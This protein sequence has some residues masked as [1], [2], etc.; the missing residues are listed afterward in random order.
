[1]EQKP[2]PRKIQKYI[3]AYRFLLEAIDEYREEMRLVQS[4][5]CREE[6][7]KEIYDKVTN[8][9]R[10]EGKVLFRLLPREERSC[11][12]QRRL[13]NLCR[14]LEYAMIGLCGLSIGEAI[15]YRQLILLLIA[16]VFFTGNRICGK[17]ID[18]LQDKVV[19]KAAVEMYQPKTVAW[20]ES[21]RMLIPKRLRENVKPL[22]SEVDPD[23]RVRA[24]IV[25]ICGSEKFRVYRHP[26]QG[27]L[28]AVCPDCGR[29]LVLF[30]DHL[31]THEADGQG[32]S[33]FANNLQMALCAS[34]K[35]ETHQVILTIGSDEH[36]TF[37]GNSDEGSGNSGYFLMYQM[38][39]SACGLNAGDGQYY[40]SGEEEEAET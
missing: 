27:Y 30:D 31:D 32:Q 29:E 11:R 9:C 34:C 14:V 33:Y 17:V 20:N 13:R 37:F 5:D 4:D 39:C 6:Q 21:Q 1:M 36:R 26:E 38:F 8:R 35:N 15:H 12:W 28:K 19:W 23:N 40:W 16:A 2:L 22:L 10:D 18:I 3:V 24:K 7:K 25:C